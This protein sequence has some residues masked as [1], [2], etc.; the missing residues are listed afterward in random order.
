MTAS[1]ST[2]GALSVWRGVIDPRDCDLLLLPPPVPPP[3]PPPP[4][5]ARSIHAYQLCGV[6]STE[7]PLQ[8]RQS[9]AARLFLLP[10]ITK[11]VIIIN[12]RS[13]LGEINIDF[14]EQT[15]SY[16]ADIN[17]LDSTFSEPRETFSTEKRV[18]V[19]TESLT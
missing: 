1:T 8:S 6:V 11:D 17:W 12:T 2:D 5:E 10:A 4:N 13:S 18:S 19:K 7:N 3:P 16:H 9:L 14:Y 15:T